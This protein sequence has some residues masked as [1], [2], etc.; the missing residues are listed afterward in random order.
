M[1]F[2]NLIV[3][4]LYYALFL[5]FIVSIIFL[6]IREINLWYWRINERIELLEKMTKSLEF[7]E[8]E[9]KNSKKITK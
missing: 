6:V 2:D 8:N 1:L 9:I 4:S 5:I 3:T 7:L